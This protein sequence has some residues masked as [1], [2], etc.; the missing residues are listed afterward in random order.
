MQIS[1]VYSREN[2][3]K[4]NAFNRTTNTKQRTH[5]DF[6]RVSSLFENMRVM[7]MT[8]RNIAVF[9][10]CFCFLFGCDFVFCELK[11]SLFLSASFQ[12][13]IRC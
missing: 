11:M 2:I 5:D 8:K 3:L 10:V 1:R 4:I 12:V 13:H 6:C 9:F 7:K